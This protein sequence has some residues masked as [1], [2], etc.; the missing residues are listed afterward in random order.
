MVMI[1]S[2][3]RCA[4]AIRPFVLEDTVWGSVSPESHRNM[5]ISASLRAQ[6]L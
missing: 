5:G 4:F 3:L 1:L 6:T 2:T